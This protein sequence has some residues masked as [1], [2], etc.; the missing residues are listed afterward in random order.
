MQFLPDYSLTTTPSE[1][2]LEHFDGLE[3]KGPGFYLSKTDTILVIPRPPQG[4]ATADS[5]WNQTQPDGTIYECH[6]W[7]CP[8]HNLVL[9][10]PTLPPTRSDSR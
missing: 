3:F 4:P 6:V 8:W 10:A 9:A 7:N 5:I 2:G 1:F